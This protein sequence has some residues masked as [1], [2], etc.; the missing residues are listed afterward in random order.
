MTLNDMKYDLKYDMTYQCS[1][2]FNDALVCLHWRSFGL[3]R[4]SGGRAPLCLLPCLAPEE[5]A[6]LEQGGDSS[7]PWQREHC[8]SCSTE[9]EDMHMKISDY[10]AHIGI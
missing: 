2:L 1:L 7:E 3:C 9:A 6:G 5:P 8:P 4:A 10:G